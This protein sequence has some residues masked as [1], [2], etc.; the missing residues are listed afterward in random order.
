MME[1]CA[2]N[3]TLLE[4]QQ[5]F[6]ARRLLY[7]RDACLEGTWRVTIAWNHGTMFIKKIKYIF[8]TLQVQYAVQTDTNELS[9]NFYFFHFFRRFGLRSVNVN[10]SADLFSSR[11]CLL[12]PVTIIPCLVG[13][14]CSQRTQREEEVA[15]II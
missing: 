2:A 9:S 4:T 14:D 11:F 5:I 1:D 6:N 7:T 15:I 8:F 13:G 3:T 10:L 12:F